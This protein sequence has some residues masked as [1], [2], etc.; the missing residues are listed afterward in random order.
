[1]T[2]CLNGWPNIHYAVSITI[3]LIVNLFAAVK[4]SPI[5][6]R[7]SF[8]MNFHKIHLWCRLLNQILYFTV[9]TTKWL[10]DNVCINTSFSS[11]IYYQ[12]NHRADPTDLDKSISMSLRNWF[13]K[14][15]LVELNA[16][17]TFEVNK[18]TIFLD[19]R[20]AAFCGPTILIFIFSWVK[21]SPIKFGS[22]MIEKNILWDYI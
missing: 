7:K 11:I 9:F 17:C 21:L 8:W 2:Q 4:S 10:Y 22:I 20:M 14:I 1:M 3:C 13:V 5:C 19:L 16:T 18:W 15:A 12:S 6:F